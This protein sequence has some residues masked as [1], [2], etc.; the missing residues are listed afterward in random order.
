MQSRKTATCSYVLNSSMYCN[1]IYVMLLISCTAIILCK[2]LYVTLVCWKYSTNITTHKMIIMSEN[3]IS[4]NYFNLNYSAPNYLTNR[5]KRVFLNNTY[6][7][8][9][10]AYINLVLLHRELKSFK[11]YFYMKIKKVNVD[12]LAT[13]IMFC[14]YMSVFFFLFFFLFCNFSSRDKM[15]FNKFI[16]CFYQ[17]S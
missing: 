14:W 11:H 4:F 16:Y 15:L 7:W 9:S 6:Q 17:V 10:I 13:M 1:L 2:Y 5:V 8:F 12:S 3:S